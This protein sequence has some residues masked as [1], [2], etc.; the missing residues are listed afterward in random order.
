MSAVNI[1]VDRLE[2]LDLGLVDVH[3]LNPRKDHGDLKPLAESIEQ[4][5]VIEPIVVVERDG[6]YHAI[7][8]SRRLAASKLAG[9]T[10]IPA[11]IMSLDDAQ[12]AAAALIENIQ[13]KDLNALEEAQAFAQYIALTGCTHKALGQKVGLAESTISNALRLIDA[14]K[15]LKQALAAGTINPAQ[16]RV[17][18]TLK[19]PG[20]VEKA[21]KDVGR[22]RRGNDD[23]HFTVE[24]AQDVVAQLNAQYMISSPKAKE[25]RKAALVAK[26]E[27]LE[28]Q[29]KT[30]TWSEN[31]TYPEEL[32]VKRYLGKPTA[33][34]A[35]SL[36]AGIGWPSHA[37]DCGCRTVELVVERTRDPKTGDEGEKII[38]RSVCTNVAAYRK[39]HRKRFGAP[40]GDSTRAPKPKTLAQIAKETARARKRAEAEVAKALKPKVP[41]AKMRPAFAKLAKSSIGADAARAIVYMYAVSGDYGFMAEDEAALAWPL[42]VKMPAKK[43]SALACSLIANHLGDEFRYLGPHRASA[44]SATAAAAY[45]GIKVPAPKKKAKGKHAA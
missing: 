35:T 2:Q 8:G 9:R 22:Y 26:R 5:G 21:M 45:F 10:R 15:P 3:E 36:G 30:V 7:A 40:G 1:P 44:G 17:F 11:R 43:L 27:E 16:A 14:P 23:A 24:D 18:L 19:D 32:A 25:A 20:L 39:W 6:R 38:V 33:K 41:D 31:E 37:K 12:A 34:I 29:G 13:R 4:I 42:V 28:K